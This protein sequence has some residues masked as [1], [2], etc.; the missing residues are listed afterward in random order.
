MWYVSEGTWAEWQGG[1]SEHSMCYGAFSPH[2]ICHR[3]TTLDINESHTQSRG[4]CRGSGNMW[5]QICVMSRAQGVNKQMYHMCRSE[6]RK[7]IE[8]WCVDL[9]GMM[10]YTKKCK[11][12]M[13]CQP[14]GVIHQ[15]SIE[16]TTGKDR[17]QWCGSVRISDALLVGGYTCSSVW[18]WCNK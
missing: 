8:V 12:V 17:Y 15:T 10:E 18:S 9:R 11:T 4:G 14:A 13:R 2:Y 16:E 5:T 6:V 1:E 3:K 7:E